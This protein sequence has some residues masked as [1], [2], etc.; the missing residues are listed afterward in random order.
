LAA[1]IAKMLG[2]MRVKSTKNTKNTFF[3]ALYNKSMEHFPITE[4]LTAAEEC[5]M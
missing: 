1:D 3:Q 2:S 4:I 5:W